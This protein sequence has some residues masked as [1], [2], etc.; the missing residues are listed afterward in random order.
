MY[1]RADLGKNLQITA[2]YTAFER[3]FQPDFYF[4]GQ[5]HNFWELVL[6]TEGTL[7]ITAGDEVFVLQ[8]GQAIL[9]EPMEFHRLWSE[10]KTAPSA[11][12]ITFE[13][14]HMPPFSSKIF[15]ITDIK[16]ATELLCEIQKAFSMRHI[17]IEGVK[18]PEGVGHQ[19]ALKKLEL[20]LLKT[21]SQR[22]VKQQEQIGKGAR[23]YA[24]I[25]Q[26]LDGNLHRIFTVSEIAEALSMSEVNLKKTF[27]RFAGMGI[28]AYFNRQKMATAISMIESGRQIQEVSRA[29]GFSNQ[30]YFSTVFRRITG[31]APSHYKVK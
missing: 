24:K 9:H 23:Q 4:A 21:L 29:L 6:V 10:K 5:H 12:F 25:V 20:F 30:N 15:E 8:K 13:A 26:F 31:T 11:I 19:I 17:Y 28:M 27:S 1:R 16:E 3:T 18:H 14:E 22:V 7:G 2:L